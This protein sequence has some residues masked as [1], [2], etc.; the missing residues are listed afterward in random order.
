MMTLNACF[1]M[2]Q[3]N[4]STPEK[5]K[6]KITHF[7]SPITPFYTALPSQ[8][9]LPFKTEEG[10]EVM[11]VSDVTAIRDSHRT[12][13]EDDQQQV[14]YPGLWEELWTQ[15]DSGVAMSEEEVDQLVVLIDHELM[16]RLGRH[17]PDDELRHTGRHFRTKCPENQCGWNKWNK[18]T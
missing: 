3:K 15:L 18:I 16:L 1:I 14:N 13:A 9:A 12:A 2:N 4:A 11:L 8:M 17:I 5:N 6:I 7:L 10:D